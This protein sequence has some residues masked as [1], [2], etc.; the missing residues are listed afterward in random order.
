MSD[1]PSFRT[2][3]AEVIRLLEEL[4]AMR[5]LLREI[6]GKLTRLQT[7]AKRAFPVAA[8]THA[9][10]VRVRKEDADTATINAGEALKHYD[11]IVEVARVESYERAATL[12][13]EM[14]LPDLVLIQREVGL[15]SGRSKPSKKAVV[16]SLLGR[17]KESVLLTHHSARPNNGP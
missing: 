4:S 17:V 11:R 14:S 2:P 8:D 1:Q 10:K 12:L 5:D 7:R 6:S 15:S 16:S 3:D 9:R 13:E